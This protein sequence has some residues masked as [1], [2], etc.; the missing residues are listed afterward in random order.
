VLFCNVKKEQMGGYAMNRRLMLSLAGAA[1][2]LFL[3]LGSAQAAPAATGLDTLR[4]LGAE[5]SN[6][7]DAHWGR[8]Y[9]RCWRHR[10]HYHCRRV[11][12]RW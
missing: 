7:Q 11:C 12:R 5:Q 2:G 1:T 8:C 6:V 9:R 10:G 4:T 3:A